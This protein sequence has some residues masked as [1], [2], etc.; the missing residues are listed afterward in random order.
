MNKLIQSTLSNRTI[1]VSASHLVFRILS[2]ILTLTLLFLSSA[3]YASSPL[4]NDVHI[5]EVLDYEEI[6][7]RNSRY[8]ATKQTLDLN[9]GEPR[10]V[11]MIYFFAQ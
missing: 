10:T 4:A 7:A 11:R 9:V 2:W 3:S 8:A 5:C 6:R 1:D